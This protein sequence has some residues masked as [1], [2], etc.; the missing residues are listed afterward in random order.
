METN[1]PNEPLPTTPVEPAA[2][3][4]EAPH[5]AGTPSTPPPAPAW[6]PPQPPPWGAGGWGAPPPWF[7]PPAPPRR[8][9]LALAIVGVIFGGIFLVFFG[10][11]LLAY[12]AVKGEAPRLGSGPRIGVV[13]VKGPIGMGDGGVDSERVLKN[14]RRFEQDS[15]IKA[16]VVRIDS[17]GGAVAPSQEIFDELRKV[18]A[19]KTVVCS[20]GNVAA[21]G[22]FYIAMGCPKGNVT[23]EPGTLTG[24]I[25]VISQFPNLSRIAQRFDFKM[26]TVKSGA[27]KDAGNPFRDMTPEDRAYWQGLIDRVYT[28]FLGAVVVSRGL[29][30]AKVRRVADGRVLT[31]A[32]ALE[33]GLVD[34]LGNFYAAV[35]QAMEAAKLKGEPELVYPADDRG[36]FLEELMGGMAGAATRAVKAELAS[37]VAEAGGPGLYFLAR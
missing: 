10:F 19:K 6:G 13:E 26:E 17:P 28:Q 23:A 31:G 9:R 3:A 8:D 2:G 21:S 7:P 37:G 20:M 32:E 33:E 5:V 22:G 24:S 11:L 16:I 36:R 25:G 1:D 34:H 14:L 18:S 35:D 12:G 30:E 27:L 29:P 4:P 15:G